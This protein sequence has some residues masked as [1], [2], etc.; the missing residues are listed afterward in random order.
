MSNVWTGRW[1]NSFGRV[2]TFGRSRPG[3]SGSFVWRSILFIA[4]VDGVLR[5]ICC[6][7]QIVDGRSWTFDVRAGWQV[8]VVIQRCEQHLDKTFR[9]RFEKHLQLTYAQISEVFDRFILLQQSQ[10][11]FGQCAWFGSTSTHTH[12]NKMK[13]LCKLVC[14][15]KSFKQSYLGSM[16]LTSQLFNASWSLMCIVCSSC[17]DAGSNWRRRFWV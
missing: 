16:Y 9:L 7:R 1:A 4:R 11:V 10:N 15:E 17:A 3:S 2:V 13:W 6:R 5:L 12:G 14:D 8:T